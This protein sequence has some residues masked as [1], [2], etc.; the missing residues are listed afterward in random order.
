M[1]LDKNEKS[2]TTRREIYNKPNYQYNNLKKNEET[3]IS[4]NDYKKNYKIL[5]Y[6]SEINKEEEE[7]LKE[8]YKVIEKELIEKEMIIENREKEINILKNEQKRLKEENR[9][10]KMQLEEAQ[11]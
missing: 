6:D 9:N 8:N 10:N 7:K 11:Y 4:L 5:P 2:Y 3:N 1:N